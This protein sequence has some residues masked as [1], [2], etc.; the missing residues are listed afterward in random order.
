[1]ASLK[2][3]FWHAFSASTKNQRQSHP[4]PTPNYSSQSHTVYEVSNANLLP[5]PKPKTSIK[6]DEPSSTAA[7]GACILPTPISDSEILSSPPPKSFPLDQLR[8]ATS[9]FCEGSLLG[10]GGSG[11]VFKGWLDNDETLTATW[12]PSG[13]PVAIKKLI[14]SGFQDHKEWLVS[15]ILLVCLVF[16]W[17]SD[18]LDQFSRVIFI[19]RKWSI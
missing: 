12:P 8:R 2:N 9:D 6:T 1:M 16:S 3:Y 7:A 17:D 19:S 18:S 4:L 5:L 14:P 13:L 15:Y 10:E 11:C